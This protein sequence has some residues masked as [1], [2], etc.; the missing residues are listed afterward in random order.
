MWTR[1]MVAVNEFGR[2]VPVIEQ[3]TINQFKEEAA[4]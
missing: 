1:W 4:S 3:A 2:P